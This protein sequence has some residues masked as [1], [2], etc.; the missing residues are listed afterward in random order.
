[1]L[2]CVLP[3]PAVPSLQ[4]YADASSVG[5]ADRLGAHEQQL[6][7]LKNLMAR[8]AKVRDGRRDVR[9]YWVGVRGEGIAST[10]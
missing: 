7:L 4:K 5:D 2:G 10:C 8:D 1:M 6:Q 3:A 9:E